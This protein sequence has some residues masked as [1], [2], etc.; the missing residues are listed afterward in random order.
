MWFVLIFCITF[1]PWFLR[2]CYD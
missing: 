1:A 2:R